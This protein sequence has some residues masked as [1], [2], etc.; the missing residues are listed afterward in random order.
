MD[1]ERRRV[2]WN[3]CYR[4]IASRYP[5]IDLFERVT[6]AADLDAV[7]ALE[8]LT[9]DRLRDEAG[10]IQLV[11]PGERVA[12]P[13]AG[14]VM[15]PFTHLSPDGGRF[16]DSRHGAYYAARSLATAIAESS[17]HRAG[18]LRATK[19]APIQLDMRVLEAGVDARVHDL[20][21]LRQRLPQYYHGDDYSAAQA[22]SLRLRAKGSDG[23]AY[24]S[25]R[26]AGGQC[27]AIF[28]P[29][30]IRG[31]RESLH[32]TFVWDGDNIVSVYEKR[33]MTL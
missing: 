16:S 32:V 8:S 30:R 12:G 10:E 13:G 28:R 15:A 22:L 26:H 6:D 31:C 5:P 20:R 1:L 3:P 18:F 29:R 24:D 14:Y 7:I 25:V 21:G 33:P 27:L 9:N 4:L 19:E 2:R 11:P 17:Y 23:V